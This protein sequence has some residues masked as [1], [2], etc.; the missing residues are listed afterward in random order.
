MLCYKCYRTAVV[1]LKQSWRPISP[2]G[3]EAEALDVV[4]VSCAECGELP[5]VYKPGNASTGKYLELKCFP[6]EIW[7]EI[8]NLCYIFGSTANLLQEEGFFLT[9]LKFKTVS[10]IRDMTDVFYIP[11]LPSKN[12][13]I[14]EHGKE[15]TTDCRF[16]WHEDFITN[17]EIPRYP[18][19]L[20][21]KALYEKGEGYMP[22]ASVANRP[23]VVSKTPDGSTL[24]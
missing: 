11:L 7:R 3:D 19:T 24:C 8:G 13:M 12:I 1:R 21:L 6:D 9:K 2:V 15:L 10:Q 17:R 23:P 14:L 5:G 4:I 20:A 18:S 16:F 22:F